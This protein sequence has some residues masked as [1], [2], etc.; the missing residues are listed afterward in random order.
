MITVRIP[1]KGTE[2]CHL[3]GFFPTITQRVVHL[4]QREPEIECQC[5]LISMPFL[6]YISI[7]QD[8]IHILNV[9]LG[10]T[11]GLNLALDLYGHCYD[12]LQ[13]LSNLSCT[14]YTTFS[15]FLRF[16]AGYR[17][18]HR[19]EGDRTTKCMQSGF[20]KLCVEIC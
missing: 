10:E 6:F 15:I 17:V 18:F 12:S 8:H 5:L 3:A 9:Q 14:I 16:F 4:K 13:K 2:F 7:L 1:K 20:L 11:S 19:V